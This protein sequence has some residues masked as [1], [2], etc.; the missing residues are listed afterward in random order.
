[1]WQRAGDGHH[2]GSQRLFQVLVIVGILCAL[3]AAIMP[4]AVAWTQEAKRC[5]CN[6]HKAVIR[7]AAEHWYFLRGSWPDR[8]LSDIGVDPRY[9]P[10]GVPKCPVDGSSYELDPVLH[11]VTGHSH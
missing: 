10:N 6:D 11:I 3:T 7:T 9:F 2:V 1:M 8:K 4:R 5:M